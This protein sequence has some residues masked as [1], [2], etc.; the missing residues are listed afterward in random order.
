MNITAELVKSA[1]NPEAGVNFAIPLPMVLIILHPPTEV[2][3]AIA[4]AQASLTHKGTWK[5]PITPPLNSAK[6]IIPIDF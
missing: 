1:E 6:D 5:L 2:P 4:V 3:S